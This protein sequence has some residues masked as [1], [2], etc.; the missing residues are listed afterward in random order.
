[1]VNK[2]E[3]LQLHTADIFEMKKH[4][5]DELDA[6]FILLCWH[7]LISGIPHS[8][9]VVKAQTEPKMNVIVCYSQISVFL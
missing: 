5:S 6:A 3:L 9:N 8:Y 7:M 2:N 4:C 1:M